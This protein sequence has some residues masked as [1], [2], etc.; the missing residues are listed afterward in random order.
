MT[1]P[2]Q[3]RNTTSARVRTGSLLRLHAAGAAGVI[4][5]LA[6]IAAQAPAASASAGRA[7]SPAQPKLTGASAPRPPGNRYRQRPVKL[8]PTVSVG[9]GPDGEVTDPATHTLYTSNQNDNSV[10]VVNTAHCH[11]G[12]TAGCAQHVHSVSLPAGASPEGIAIDVA[13]GTL[14]VANIGSNT[15]S[16]VNT[17]TCN[18]VHFSGCG[19]APASAKDPRGPI[20]LAVDPASDTVYVTDVGDNFSGKGRT[21][22]VINGA[23]CNGHRHTGCGQTPPTVRVGRGPDGVAVD[24]A[25]Q[26]VYVVNDGPTNNSHTVSVINAATCNGQRHSGCGQTAATIQIGHGPFW[27]AL[28]Q[29]THTA[30]TAN[31]TD[32]TVSV[33]NTATCNAHRHSGCGQRTA[34]VPV[35]FAPWALAIDSAQ[36]TVFVA[37]NHDDTMS[38]INSAT[39]DAAHRS[40]CG[41]QPATSQV[42][43]GPQAVI[44]D[45]ATGTVYAAN[46]TDSTV[47]VIDP[48]RCNAARTRG[49]RHPAPTAKVGAG[50]DGLAVDRGTST[51]YVA[52][53]GNNTV[54]VIS[55]AT[56]NARRRAGCARPAA[57]IHAGPGPAGVAVDQATDT[58]YVA[59]AGGDTVSVINGAACNARRHSGCSQ[60]PPSVTVGA[61]PFGIA[62]D[63]ATNSVYV[64]SLGANDLGDTVS[65]I[66]GATC[67]ATHHSGCGQ[68]APTVKVGTGPFGIAVSQAT[69]TIYV[70]NTGQLFAGVLGHTVSVINGATCNGVQ[71][72]GCGLAPATVTVGPAPF[73]IAISQATNTIYVANNNGGDGPSSL[74]VI[75]GATCDGTNT[76][77][78]GT[79]PPV[80]P[81]VGRAPNGI[82]LDQ[83]THTVYTANAFDA[84]VSVVNV[85]RRPIRHPSGQPPRVA[86]GSA[87]EAI[88]IDH[89]NHTIYIADTFSGTISILPGQ[90]VRAAAYSPEQPTRLWTPAPR[91]GLGA[92]LCEVVITECP[93]GSLEGRSR[94]ASA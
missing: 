63:Q 24:P 41:H 22:T 25:T 85:T 35:G 67:D 90:P 49:C 10:S 18:A 71:H 86:V 93:K 80:I 32:S 53:G 78:C 65:V 30:Y 5:V 21:V 6:G 76:T 43:K 38:A 7:A 23:T 89:G 15:I 68:T 47:S 27:I 70:A 54:S 17:R 33:I 88:A 94:P 52:N 46:F 66:D 83:M 64:T 56:C 81:G 20:A 9:N 37:N 57:T 19:Q 82:A 11:A 69:D 59:D 13:T 1:R 2:P 16:V 42:G 39:C 8:P 26:T 14:Y 34:T 55:A 91:P 60:T 28:D 31:F 79:T 36:R 48:A 44:T 58:V 62:V 73:G 84:T 74:S 92:G 50:P 51:V 87:P 3:A 45:P 12:D 77:G 72:T 75:D 61:S 40:G 29:A 4:L